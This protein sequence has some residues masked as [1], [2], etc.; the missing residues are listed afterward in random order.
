MSSTV[1]QNIHERPV[2]MLQALIRFNTTNPPGNEGACVDYINKLLAEAGLET[3]IL[4][5]DPDRPNLI[6]R[7]KGKG[8]APPLM[9][10]GHVDVVTTTNQQW[11]HPPF[12]G[13]VADGYVWGRGALD[14][15]GGIAMMLAAILRAK[16]E[17]ISPAG[18]VIFTALSDEEGGGDYGARY[19]AENHPELFEGVRYAVGEFGGFSL[20]MGGKKFYPI[21][22]AEKQICW[23]KATVRGPAGHGSL[24]MR[25]GAMARLGNLLQQLDKRRLPVHITPVA[26]RMIETMVSSLSFPASLVLRQLLNPYLT[27]RILNRLGERGRIF[28]PMLHNTVNAT[29]VKGGEKINVIPGEVVLELDGRLLPG[30]RPDDIMAELRRVIGVEMALEV[31]RHDPCPPEPDMGLFETLSNVICEVDSDGIPLPLL[32]SGTSDARFFS[33]LNI[34]TYGFLPMNLPADFNFGNTIHAADERIPVE[35]VDFGANAVYKLLQRY[36]E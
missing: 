20:C 33:Q 12:E 32:L 5:K 1:S 17:G 34:Q 29:I 27:D 26:R 24:P 25:G 13:K 9:L 21:Q 23:M 28:E 8:S 10:Y 3:V 14:M 19:L 16:S 31:I 6:A 35:A 22:V 30:Y 36:G 7:M 18:D 15:K 2:E 4:A 11:T